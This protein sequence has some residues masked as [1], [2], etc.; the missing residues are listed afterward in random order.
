MLDC[1]TRRSLHAATAVI[2]V[3]WVKITCPKVID[4]TCGRHNLLQ[5]DA[6]ATIYF[7]F[8]KFINKI[9]IMEFQNFVF[10]RSWFRLNWIS[11]SKENRLQMNVFHKLQAGGNLRNGMIHNTRTRT[12]NN[13]NSFWR[14]ENRW[15]QHGDGMAAARSMRTLTR[16]DVAEARELCG[17]NQLLERSTLTPIKLIHPWTNSERER[18]HAPRKTD[19]L[20]CGCHL[21]I[22]VLRVLMFMLCLH[23]N[24]VRRNSAGQADASISSISS[25]RARR[26]RVINEFQAPHQQT[27]DAVINNSFLFLS[28]DVAV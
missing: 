19:L 5:S 7:A 4:Y 11:A 23:P 24:C 22:V 12:E 18:E 1:L 21:L 2:D 16:R 26:D 27:K 17:P 8:W 9:A 6:R 14:E 3:K 15:K 28:A 25:R 20:C 13:N 10:S